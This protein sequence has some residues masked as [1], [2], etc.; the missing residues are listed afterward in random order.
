VGAGREW[1]A[2]ER[3]LQPRSRADSISA[4]VNT[5]DL[6]Y[7]ETAGVVIESGRAFTN[8]DRESSTPVAIVNEQM[9]RDD[10][11]AGA[12]ENASSWPARNKCG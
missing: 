2:G 9:A 3:A 7:F 4:L 10:W 6:G 12:C 8:M 5:V 11:P 1:A